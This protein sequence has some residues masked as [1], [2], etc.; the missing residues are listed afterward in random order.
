M[1]AIWK[2][3]GTQGS[4][5]AALGLRPSTAKGLREHARAGHS[6]ITQARTRAKQYI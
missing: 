1:R 4:A 2:L 5:R 6:P 3:E